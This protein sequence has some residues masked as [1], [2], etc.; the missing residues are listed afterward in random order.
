M[1]TDWG[2]WINAVLGIGSLVYLASLSAK[3]SANSEESY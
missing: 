3:A 2:I 1:W